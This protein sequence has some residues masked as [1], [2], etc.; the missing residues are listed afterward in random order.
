LS[1]GVHD[2]VQEATSAY[3]NWSGELTDWFQENNDG[4]P[5]ALLIATAA[6]DEADAASV[7]HAANKLGQ[8]VS[9]P[10]EPGG[11]L[12]SDGITTLLHQI[13][14]EFTSD[15]RIR[16]PRPAYATSV[17]DHVWL[18]RP[19][20]RADL[21]RWLVDLP[22][23]LH[24]PA[25]E[26]A[27]YSLIDLAIRHGDATLITDAVG[28][29]AKQP[30]CRKLAA[31]ALTEAG[32]SGSIGRMVRRT[33]Y[34][35]ATGTTTDES[36]QLTV[37]DVCGGPFGRNFPRNA[38]TRLRHLAVRGG[39][40]VRD[41]VTEALKALAAEP[42]LRDSILRDVVGWITDAGQARVPGI[43]AFLALTA[44]SAKQFMPRSPADTSRMELL[45]AGLRA[46]LHDPD[47]VEQAREACRGWIEAAAHGAVPRHIVTDIIARTC[48][49]SHDIGL[50]TPVIW[51]WA[52]AD[53]EP[54]TVPRRELC[55]ELLQKLA[56]RDSLAPGVS[57]ETVYRATS[58][59]VR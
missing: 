32:V 49:D 34:T 58:E 47:H 43:G 3:Q 13:G 5:R 53:I 23:A 40:K 54:T 28:T 29:W 1:S 33:M 55:T 24:D 4:Y 12:V 11:G 14:A 2:P 35:W 27:G 15:G 8:A 38:M 19:H 41:G 52:Q 21:R 9:L 18:D 51:R 17:L 30:G 59:E 26:Y 20:L 22:G 31:S 39:P 36:L 46:A 16:L 25:T 37:A 7:F 10:R 48:E 45:S 44:G 50:L 6:L 56:D 42:G 57:A